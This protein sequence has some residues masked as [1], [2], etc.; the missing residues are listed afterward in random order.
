MNIY[1][2]QKKVSKSQIVP[3]DDLLLQFRASSLSASWNFYQLKKDELETH[4]RLRLETFQIIRIAV[5]TLKKDYYN[6]NLADLV[7]NSA[8]SDK[9]IQGKDKLIRKKDPVFL[10]PESKT[11]RSHFYAPVKFIGPLAV[12]TLWFNIAALWLMSI[13]LYLYV[14]LLGIK[15]IC[16][17]QL[18]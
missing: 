7:L 3:M 4:L 2:K 16:M 8:S 15:G 13:I 14:Q 18:T 1:Y 11:G 5:Y 17:L 9:V 10:D 6:E 12:N